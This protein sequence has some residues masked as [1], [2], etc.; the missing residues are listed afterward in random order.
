MDNYTDIYKVTMVDRAYRDLDG[1]YEY[2][3]TTLVEPEIALSIADDIETAILSLDTFPHRYPER[4]T[5][6]YA[7]KGYRQLFVGNY[8]ALFRIDEERKCV[9]VLTI[10]YSASQF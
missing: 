8:T 10:R 1:I 2:I 5:G 6:A 4:R 7:N 3:A 9:I